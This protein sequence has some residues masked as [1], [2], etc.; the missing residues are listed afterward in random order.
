MLI[1]KEA[2]LLKWLSNQLE[3]I[4]EADPAALASYVIALLKHH[5]K[6][7]DVLKQHCSEQLIDF[8]GDE[9][10]SFLESLFEVLQNGSYVDSTAPDNVSVVMS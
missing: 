2:S 1:E 10:A 8:F 4:T 7:G 5:D 3:N 6:K 9:T